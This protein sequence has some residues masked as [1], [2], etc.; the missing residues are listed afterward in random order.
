MS[1]SFVPSFGTETANLMQPSRSEKA[2]RET[3]QIVWKLF[4]AGIETLAIR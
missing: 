2:L 1:H 3:I 4:I